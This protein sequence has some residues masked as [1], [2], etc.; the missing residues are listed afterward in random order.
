MRTDN[1]L[2]SAFHKHPNSPRTPVP[3]RQE[4]KNLFGCSKN[5][6][7]SLEINTRAVGTWFIDPK[8]VCKIFAAGV[9]V[10]GF[11]CM[12]EN[13]FIIFLGVI[14][15][16]VGLISVVRNEMTIKSFVNITTKTNVDDYNYTKMPDDVENQRNQTTMA[17]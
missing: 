16:V 4:Q 7:T 11:G 9:A 3:I 6:M 5:T 12:V 17:S 14:P 1:L 10:I 2:D 8:N 15:T 13:S